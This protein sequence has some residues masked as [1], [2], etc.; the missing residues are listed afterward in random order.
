MGGG[1]GIVLCCGGRG[2]ENPKKVSQVPRNFIRPKKGIPPSEKGG[3]RN[4]KGVDMREEPASRENCVCEGGE[5]QK[6]G[7]T[8]DLGKPHIM[9]GEKALEA[10]LRKV[11]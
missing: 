7:N 4:Q 9:G 11:R 5:G 1:K 10:E 6:E 3:E 2:R 8:S